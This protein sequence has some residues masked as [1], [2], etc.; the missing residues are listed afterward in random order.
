MPIGWLRTYVRMGQ[1]TNASNLIILTVDSLSSNNDS[2]Y[3]TLPLSDSGITVDIEYKGFPMVR[4]EW[5]RFH[6]AP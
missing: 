2:L 6:Y 1:N 3:T 4:S 5:L